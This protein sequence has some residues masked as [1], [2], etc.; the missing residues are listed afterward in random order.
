MGRLEIIMRLAF[1]SVGPC[2]QSVLNASACWSCHTTRPILRDRLHF[3]ATGLIKRIGLS[4]K[5]CLML[6][7]A[8]NHLAPE[9]WTACCVPMSNTARCAV[10]SAIAIIM[11]SVCLSVYLRRYALW[12][13][14]TP[15]AKVPEQANRKSIAAIFYPYIPSKCKSQTFPSCT[16]GY[17]SNSWA[18]TH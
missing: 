7:K 18:N 1:L 9:S 11:S 3:L 4:F 12:L 5:L 13:N 14:D 16:I 15:A 2:V 17:L 6:F 8:L 10:R